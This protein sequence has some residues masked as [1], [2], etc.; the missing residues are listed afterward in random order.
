[1]LK[2]VAGTLPLPLCKWNISGMI[3][4]YFK[5]NAMSVLHFVTLGSDS[6]PVW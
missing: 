2:K 4:Y 5:G 6:G 3:R 1:M